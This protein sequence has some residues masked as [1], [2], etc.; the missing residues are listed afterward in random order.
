MP[1]EKGDYKQLKFFEWAVDRKLIKDLPG[2]VVRELWLM[3]RHGNFPSGWTWPGTKKKESLLGLN[4]EYQIKGLYFLAR[5]GFFSA[6]GYAYTGGRKGLAVRLS[7]EV[8]KREVPSAK[9]VR[10]ELYDHI[11]RKDEGGTLRLLLTYLTTT[12]GQ[13]Y[14]HIKIEKDI[15]V[16]NNTKPLVVSQ[17]GTTKNK[18]TEKTNKVTYRPKMRSAEEINADMEK[19]LESKYRNIPS[20]RIHTVCKELRDNGN[21]GDEWFPKANAILEKAEGEIMSKMK[22][23][24]QIWKKKA[25]L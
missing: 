18:E 3:I 20:E 25:G 15:T 2:Y 1:Y 16:L 12:L 19:D 9:D 23:Q 22:E 21:K 4:Y 7:L 6:W 24:M 14:D 11:A 10:G 5:K 13:P 17:P 8:P